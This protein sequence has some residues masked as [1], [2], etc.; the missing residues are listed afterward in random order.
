MRRR[1]FLGLSPFVVAF[2][3]ID[4]PANEEAS[5][6]ESIVQIRTVNMSILDA[7]R[8]PLVLLC[9]GFPETKHAWRHQVDALA[10]AGYRVV[11][12]V[13]MS[14]RLEPACGSERHI[15]PNHRPS[16]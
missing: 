1:E 6:K 13:R 16:I 9:H 4:L 10:Q 3:T 11:A 8:G 15:V 2:P 12:L 5:V 7:G 14:P